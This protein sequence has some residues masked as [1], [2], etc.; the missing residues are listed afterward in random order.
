MTEH[1]T[2]L[3]GDCDT[4][5]AMVRKSGRCPA[6]EFIQSLQFRFQARYER[7]FERLRDHHQIKTPENLRKLSATENGATVYELKVDKYRLYIV[8]Y[9]VLWV[10][11]HGG[12]KPGGNRVQ[13]EIDKAFDIF[14][15][16][17]G[18]GNEWHLP[19]Q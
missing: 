13:A 14:W 2:R 12:V 3:L 7:Y 16:W 5:V 15:E 6:V 10:A 11:T 17:N 8:K 1:T 18:E 9:N 19:R 4:V